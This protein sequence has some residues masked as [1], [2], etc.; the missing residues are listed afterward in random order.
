[1]N[2]GS[3]VMM[4]GE[5]VIAVS[6]SIRE[7]I[8]MNYP[9]VDA[10]CIEVIPR[11][12]DPSR[13]H[14]GFIP[15]EQWERRWRRE[16]PECRDRASLVLPGRITRLKGHHDFLRIVAELKGRGLLVHG[17][18]V[19]GVAKGKENYAREVESWRDE[20][21]LHDDVSMIGARDDLCEIL[22]FADLSFSLS[23]Q[24]ESF[25][26]TVCEALSLGRPVI[27]YDHGGVGEQLE[28]LFPEG[29]V[30]PGDWRLATDLAEKLLQGHSTVRPNETFLLDDM[31]RRTLTLY[32]A[33]AEGPS[34]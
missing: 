8:E 21:G 4:R 10:S 12:I 27:G 22:A 34:R 28:V 1:V 29:R 3:S 30:K 32:E 31:L 25:G 9:K 18:V 26:R 13:Y 7:Y 11:G 2:F 23:S 20:L 6:G 5:R 19:G 14:P 33:L 16:F 17:F 15:G 24:P